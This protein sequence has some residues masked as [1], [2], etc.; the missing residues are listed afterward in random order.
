[1]KKILYFLSF[2]CSF[3]SKAQTDLALIDLY[4]VD[5]ASSGTVKKFYPYCHN[6]GT[7]N[8]NYSAMTIHWQINGGAV[9]TAIPQN[10]TPSFLINGLKK[11]LNNPAMAFQVPNTPGTYP[12]KVWIT[13]AGTDIN[14]NNDTI[15]R[16]VKVIDNLPQKN[17]VLETFK[18]Q[19]CGPCYPADTMIKNQIDIFQHYHSVGI[20]TYSGDAIF[21]ADGEALENQ[22]GPYAHPTVVFDHF[23]F[24]GET[25]FGQSFGTYSGTLL[26]DNL[27]RRDEFLE[28]VEVSFSKLGID[29]VARTLSVELSAKFYDALS[30]DL[31]FN[32]YILEDSI[33][34]YQ[35]SA[36]N[37]SNY[38]HTRVLRTILGGTW[39]Q[40][41]SIPSS[42]S[43]GQTATYTFNFTVPAN[44]DM[45]MLRLVGMV[46]KYNTS[47]YDRRILNSNKL[48]VRDYWTT[49]LGTNNISKDV[50]INIYPNPTSQYLNID[51][52]DKNIQFH[53]L[54]VM[55]LDGKTVLETSYTAQLNIEKLA[56]GS[57]YL[58]LANDKASYTKMF[59]KN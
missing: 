33:I 12:L 10:T 8:V 5:Y 40:A 44:F 31:R 13:I 47:L 2:F 4:P 28:P 15:T 3:I 41:S 38:I 50:E 24:P 21:S 36:P 58:I 37:P 30:N 27:F 56:S 20:Y 59:T 49:P 42:V 26:L 6:M 52:S 7:N 34:G 46:Q 51:L 11:E 9:Q 53:S 18:H 17:V 16:M 32:L 45:R 29:K 39:G 48:L 25:G 22:L 19:A 54:K 14:P 55:S 43:A 23:R 35:A 1:M 57:Y